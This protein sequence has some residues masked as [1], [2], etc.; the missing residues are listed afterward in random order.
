MNISFTLILFLFASCSTPKLYRA[1]IGIS[2]NNTKFKS[3]TKND[4]GNESTD[5]L[6]VESDN[7]LQGAEKCSGGGFKEDK[8]VGYW[9]PWIEFVPTYFGNSSFGFSYF[10][11]FNRSNATLLDYPATDSKTEVEIDRISFNPIIFLNFGDKI[12]NK[13]GGLSFRVGLGSA[14]NYVSKFKMKRLDTDEEI[15][16]D[17]K[18]KPGGSAFL[19]FNWNWFIFRV[20]NSQIEYEGRKFASTNNDR[21]VVENN[22]L[23]L[24]YSYYFN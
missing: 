19:E 2:S 6:C 9:D 8:G 21:L 22:K 23:S 15:N 1:T 20:E 17:T 12:I 14:I 3:I 13:S 7:D 24:Y 10:F 16:V 4:N 18:I 11:A 5:H